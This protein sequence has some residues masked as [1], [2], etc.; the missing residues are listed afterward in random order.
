MIFE[1][2]FSFCGVLDSRS[3]VPIV[4]KQG[5]RMTDL[6]RKCPS[7][8]VCHVEGPIFAFAVHKSV[9]LV[10]SVFLSFCADRARVGTATK[11]RQKEI[12]SSRQ[13]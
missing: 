12:Y 13:A 8:S 2:F 1:V 3:A 6:G 7:Q 9:C 5:E 10:L 4:R 11:H